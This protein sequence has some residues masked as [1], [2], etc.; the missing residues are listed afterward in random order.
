MAQLNI[1]KFFSH[2]ASALVE[3]RKKCIEMHGS[4]IRAAGN[5]VEIAVRNWL[6]RMLPDTVSVGHGHIIDS[7]SAISPQLD[8][9]IRDRSHLPTLFTASDGTE[10]TPIDSVFA[11]GE[12][13]SSYSNSSRHIQKFSST[14]KKIK[15]DLKHTLIENTAK[16]GVKENSL[17]HHLL[18]GSSQPYLNQIFT[19][20]LFIHS[21]DAST[22]EI[23]EIYGSTDDN[24]LPDIVVFLN[25]CVVVKAEIEGNR[26]QI[27]RYSN[28]APPG[29]G[30]KI[31][32][33][34]KIEGTDASSEGKHLGFLYYCLL[35]HIKECALEGPNLTAY[36]KDLLV[37]QKFTIIPIE[38]QNAA[39]NGGPAASVDNSNTP[40]GSRHR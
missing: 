34:P 29:V 8:C 35:S 12:V 22:D 33:A 40:G 13:K 24:N 11:Y 6:Q 3:A 4:D 10:Y 32:P 37:G 18:L 14:K 9:I 20:M 7:S 39:P 30:W 36:M 38:P 28:T 5:E 23:K 1:S 27:Y 19:F 31:I 15:E 2:E 26:L 25:G 21:G 17:L 16:D